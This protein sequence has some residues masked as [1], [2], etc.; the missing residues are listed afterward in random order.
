MLSRKL[1][2]RDVHLIHFEEIL[3]VGIPILLEFGILGFE[4]SVLQMGD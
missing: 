1:I 4:I 2:N 3:E